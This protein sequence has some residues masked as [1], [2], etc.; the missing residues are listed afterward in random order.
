MGGTGW[1]GMVWGG[2]ADKF[3]GIHSL[4]FLLVQF[5]MYVGMKTYFGYSNKESDN[6]PSK[7]S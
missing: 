1:G 5:F 6:I 3:V 2:G 7:S 4:G